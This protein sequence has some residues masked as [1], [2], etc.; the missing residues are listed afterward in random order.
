MLQVDLTVTGVPATGRK[1]LQREMERFATLL[2]EARMTH[3]D[4]VAT[5]RIPIVKSRGARGCRYLHLAGTQKD[6]TR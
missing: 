5:A 6:R 4:V 2:R 1:T 3:I